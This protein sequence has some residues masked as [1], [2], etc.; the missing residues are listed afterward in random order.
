[1]HSCM[2]VSDTS[3]LLHPQEGKPLVLNV[4]RK[5]EQKLLNDSSRIKVVCPT[6]STTCER[7]QHCCVQFIQSPLARFLPHYSHTVSS[8]LCCRPPSPLVTCIDTCIL[9]SCLARL[10]SPA[11]SHCVSQEYLP[12]GGNPTFCRLTRELAFGKSSQAIQEGRIATVQALSGTGA[13]RVGA[14]FLAQHYPVKIVYLP[15]P[16][17]GNHTNIFKRAGHN[18]KGYRYF[19]PST[20]GLDYQVKRVAACMCSIWQANM[21][22]R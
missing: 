12:I 9:C 7:K 22:I 2:H 18:V 11:C 14:E 5:A 8:L 6:S 19:D 10:L 17:W 21:P 16:T 1:M 4:V 15:V 13:L 20:R 3:V